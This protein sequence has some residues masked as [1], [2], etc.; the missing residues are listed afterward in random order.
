MKER[1]RT[2]NHLVNTGLYLLLKNMPDA[3]LF[4]MEHNLRHPLGIYNISSGRVMAG[5]EGVIK[6]SN[7]INYYSDILKEH[8]RILSKLES[9][10]SG[11]TDLMARAQID[12][13]ILNIKEELK[14]ISARE[15]SEHKNLCD[16]IKE[17]LDSMMAFI[18][19][20]YH[21]LKCFYPANS[22]NQKIQFADK[23]ME[24]VEPK[25]VR[26][27]KSRLNEYR[28][29]LAPMVNKVKH[30]HARL[31]IIEFR[32]IHGIIKGYYI[33]GLDA[34]G[35]LGTDREVHKLFRNEDTAFSLNRDMKFHLINFYF[36]CHYLKVLI[37]KI[38]KSK[39]NNS[40]DFV[41]HVFEDG[42]A[43]LNVIESVRILPTLFFPDEM[44]KPIPEINVIE[45]GFEVIL[46][47]GKANLL[48]Y[49][50]TE[51]SC[52]FGGDGISKTFRLP[53]YTPRTQKSR[54]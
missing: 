17:L 28:S 38:I 27:Y 31:H 35:Y 20:T 46:P 52:S 36:I 10:L 19:D 9:D 49:D 40:I 7:S 13:A 6:A 23:W 32:T 12:E 47:G 14:E 51:I 5:F 11:E 4:N 37:E 41:N 22:V 18:D 16:A 3:M 33:E 15:G 48:A 24:K 50:N 21:I 45:D 53:Y 8:N 2:Q 34:D 54:G 29:I 42:E 39:H 25:L 43:N 44:I 26:E 30:N 1:I